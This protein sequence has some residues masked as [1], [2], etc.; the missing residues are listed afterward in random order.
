MKVIEQIVG[1]YVRIEPHTD[2]FLPCDRYFTVRPVIS[3]EFSAEIEPHSSKHGPVRLHHVAKSIVGGLVVASRRDVHGLLA[4]GLL[5]RVLVSFRWPK[6]PPLALRLQKRIT[7]SRDKF[8]RPK[9]TAKK[10]SARQIGPTSDRFD[11]PKNKRSLLDA[12]K[13]D[14]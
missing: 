4:S 13:C 12:F 9:K 2:P 3:V 11:P 1:L 10:M 8:L 14:T 7:S 6:K 5:R